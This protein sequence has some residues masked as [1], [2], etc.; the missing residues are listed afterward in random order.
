MLGALATIGTRLAIGMQI[1]R[2]LLQRLF[3]MEIVKRN[4]SEASLKVHAELR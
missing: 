3:D 4:C 1:S 2:W